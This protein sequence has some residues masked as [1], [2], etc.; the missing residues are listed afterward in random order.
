MDVLNL[1]IFLTL[2]QETGGLHICG[3][4]SLCLIFVGLRSS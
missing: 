4:I 2:S 1:R 3:E